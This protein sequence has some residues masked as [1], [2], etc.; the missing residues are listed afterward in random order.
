[1]H[2]SDAVFELLL[3]VANGSNGPQV[4]DFTIWTIED[5]DSRTKLD[6]GDMVFE[7]S[8][9]AIAG[10]EEI[11]ALSISKQ[12]SGD[13][14]DL[15]REFD[16]SLHI[17]AHSLVPVGNENFNHSNIVAHIL[18]SAGNNIRSVALSTGNNDFSLGHGQRLTIPTLPAGTIWSVNETG[19]LGYAP[20]VLVTIGTESF[21]LSADPGSDLSTQSRVVTNT[22]TNSAAYTNTY[23]DSLLTGLLVSRAPLMLAALIALTII[24]LL[25]SRRR[26]AAITAIR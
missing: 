22:G 20:S 6:T 11:P 8:F 15:L 18:D 2:Y 10:T 16:F 24:A 1:M 12:V 9:V 19:T 4:V 14:A 3:H 26:Q 13:F 5:S 21:N 7:N 25:V 23:F 17:T